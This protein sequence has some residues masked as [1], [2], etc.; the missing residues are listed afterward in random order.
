[1]KLIVGLGNPGR[2]YEQTRHNLGF[3]VVDR[4]ATRWSIS[5]AREKF[6]ARVGDGAVGGVRTM[7]M[8]PMTFMNRSGTSVLAAVQFHKVDPAQDLLVISDDLDLPVGRLRIRAQGASGGHKGLGDIQARLGSG[9]FARLR[10]G[11]DKSVE[12]AV[13]HVLATFR[14]EEREPVECAIDR[15][16]DAAECW[17]RD[18]ITTVMNRYNRA[19]SDNPQNNDTSDAR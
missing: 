9:D 4:L 19:E 7:L 3:R 2:E 16:A 18:G 14:P 11:I 13:E 5:V 17:L 12:D 6:Q 8:K 10:I 1:M 15:A